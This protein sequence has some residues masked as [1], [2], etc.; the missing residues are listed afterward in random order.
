MPTESLALAIDLADLAEQATGS[1]TL[2]VEA[3]AQRLLDRHPEA[4]LSEQ[5][6]AAV[7]REEAD[8]QNR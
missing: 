1:H 3:E 7:L 2:D 5:E 6:V 8:Q 4:P